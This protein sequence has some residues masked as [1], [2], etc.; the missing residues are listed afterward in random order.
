MSVSYFTYYITQKD[1]KNHNKLSDIIKPKNNNE[2]IIVN[3]DYN[4]IIRFDKDFIFDYLFIN[5]GII[6]NNGNLIIKENFRNHL[7]HL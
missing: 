2:I 1:I 7:E 4:Q 3:N 6:W 5:S